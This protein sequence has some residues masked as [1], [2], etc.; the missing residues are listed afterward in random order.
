MAAPDFIL[1]HQPWAG[2]LVDANHEVVPHEGNVVL[3]QIGPELFQLTHLITHETKLIE[4]PG[5]HLVFDDGQGCLVQEAKAQVG[6]SDAEVS[7]DEF[8]KPLACVHT[9]VLED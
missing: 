1:A 6:E 5:W 3:D 7:G 9:P 8:V 2:H 4:G